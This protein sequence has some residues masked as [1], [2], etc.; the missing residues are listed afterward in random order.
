MVLQ[1]RLLNSH[2]YAPASAEAI[3]LV[4]SESD[5]LSD[6]SPP[7]FGRD[8]A[9]YCTKQVCS[10]AACTVSC[11]RV[12]CLSPGWYLLRLS[13]APRHSA[14]ATTRTSRARL[15]PRTASARVK[16]LRRP[17]QPRCLTSDRLRCCAVPARRTATRSDGHELGAGLH[18]SRASARTRVVC[19][20]TCAPTSRSRAR[21]GRWMESAPRL[22]PI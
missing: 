16:I 18:R 8:V 13:A 5:V 22:P 21:L 1:S 15:G 7:D 3:C 14:S 10:T 12:S 19:A 20:P 17:G 9:Y 4:T 2:C 6:P 11:K